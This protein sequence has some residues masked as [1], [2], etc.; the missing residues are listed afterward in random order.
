MTTVSGSVALVT[1]GQ[2]G[3]GR[4]FAQALLDAGAAKVYVTA[5]NPVPTDD[6]RLVPLPFDV[7]DEQSVRN[8]ALAAPD[9]TIVVNN[10]GVTVPAP[11]TEASLADARTIFETNVFGPLRVAQVFAPI[12]AAN[13]GG[14]LVDIHSVLSWLA[15]SG[16]YGASKAALW[17]LTNSLRPVLG[18]AGT[19]V[20]GVHL[21]YAD[22]D[23]TARLDVPKIDPA[24]VARGMVEALVAG[25][26]E[27]LADDASRWAKG[28]LSGPPEALAIV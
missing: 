23:M 13:G 3:L 20:L 1:G 18:K 7:T 26:S 22:T 16:L 27:Y 8:L 14:A 19:Q 24:D 17:S 9:V 12:L 21:G 15:G 10:A 6:P 28:A 25:D 2:R 11:V 5:R 4:A